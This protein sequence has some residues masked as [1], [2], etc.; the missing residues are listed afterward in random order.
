MKLITILYDV[1]QVA[2]EETI[3]KRQAHKTKHLDKREERSIDAIVI[4]IVTGLTRPTRDMSE[5]P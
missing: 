5:Q 2:S 4:I 3:P 1:E